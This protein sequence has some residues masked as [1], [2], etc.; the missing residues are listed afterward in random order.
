MRRKYRWVK[1]EPDTWITGFV[2]EDKTIWDD[3]EQVPIG[4]VWV[5]LSR[6]KLYCVS[7][8]HSFEWEKGDPVWPV[9]FALGKR[10]LYYDNNTIHPFFLYLDNKPPK[11][12]DPELQAEL[13]RALK[14]N[15]DQ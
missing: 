9:Y 8:A 12:I 2:F 15:P 10:G 4:S 5:G 6:C 1:T 3:E 11:P 14:I 7:T 13:D